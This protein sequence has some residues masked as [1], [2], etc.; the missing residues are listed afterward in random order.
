MPYAS[1]GLVWRDTY[2]KILAAFSCPLSLVQEAYYELDRRLV[3]GV[4]GVDNGVKA[5]VGGEFNYSIISLSS[6]VSSFNLAW[7]ES[8]NSDNAFV[9]AVNIVLPIV[10]RLITSAI[11][12]V[13]SISVV[14]AAIDE[15]KDNIVVLPAPGMPWQRRIFSKKSEKAQNALFVVYPTSRGGYGVQAIP[16]CLGSFGQKCPFPQEWRG[17][18]IEVLKQLTGLKDV[19]FCH[20]TGFFAAAES[21]DSAIKLAK[22]AQK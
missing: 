15:S 20:S 17:A 19:Q 5:T 7:D 22:L 13:K 11:S 12:A 9:D 4:D 3:E 18:S 2:K 21:I 10:V 8:G 1:A 16:P 14:D 6:I